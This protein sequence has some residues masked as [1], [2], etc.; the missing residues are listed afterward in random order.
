MLEEHC[1]ITDASNK[2]FKGPLFNDLVVLEAR[3][4]KI[5]ARFLLKILGKRGGYQVWIGQK[6]LYCM[7]RGTQ[8]GKYLTH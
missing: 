1:Y 7:K 5:I 8:K 4:F 6:L 2:T 3:M